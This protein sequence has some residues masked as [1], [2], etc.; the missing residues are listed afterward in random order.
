ML[1]NHGL[2][3]CVFL[4][5]FSTCLAAQSRPVAGPAPAEPAA[6]Q[7]PFDLTEIGQLLQGGL[8]AQRIVALV[9]QYGVS[10]ALTDDAENRLRKLGA[11][12]RLLAVIAN[13]RVRPA[14]NVAA[15]T[16]PEAPAPQTLQ[17]A[18][19]WTDPATRLMWA[20]ESNGGNVT[21]NQAKDYCANLGLGGYSNWRLATLEELEGIYDEKQ[22]VGDCHVKGGIRFHDLCWSWSSSPGIDSGE[23][24]GFGFLSGQQSSIPYEE[25]RYN[26]RTLCV[27]RSG[28]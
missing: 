11:G 19:A 14:P 9:Q 1:K 22:N 13:S 18:S 10:F 23:A 7:E 2:R 28:K 24:W 6:A 16:L 12:D 25:S 3:L 21:W 4:F 15:Q 26:T 20:K 8:T 5:L 27:R 17:S